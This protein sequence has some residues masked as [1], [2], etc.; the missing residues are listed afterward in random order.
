MKEHD[1]ESLEKGLKSNTYFNQDFF[2]RRST[3]EIF[4]GFGNI[5]NNLF[6]YYYKPLFLESIEETVKTL[7]ADNVQ[8]VEL[9]VVLGDKFDEE[10]KILTF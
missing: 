1:W 10:G 7:I 9:R 8:A 2:H 5:F 3:C 6:I 4:D